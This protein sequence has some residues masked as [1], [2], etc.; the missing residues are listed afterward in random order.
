MAI[1]R[2]LNDPQGLMAA[3]GPSAVGMGSSEENLIGDFEEGTKKSKK[4]K[5]T[6]LQ[7]EFERIVNDRQKFVKEFSEKT[8]LDKKEIYNLLNVITK[9]VEGMK[10]NL[11]VKMMQEISPVIRKD[12]L[13]I[14]K[15]SETGKVQDEQKAIQ[16]LDELQ[17]KFNLD[18]NQFNKQLGGNLDKLLSAVDGMK[19]DTEKRIQ[20]AK[21]IQAE[22]LQKGRSTTI[23]N[24]NLRYLSPIEIKEKQQ[25]ANIVERQVIKLEK[26]L[27]KLTS[28]K[29]KE[30]TTYSEKEQQDRQRIR[31]R[32]EFNRE[33]LGGIKSEI[34]DRPE[35]S[36]SKF[37]RAI[38]NVGG[39][40]RGEK[41]PELI[42]TVIGGAYQTAISP[43]Y[44]MQ[45][46][47]QSMNGALLGL[48]GLLASKLG[49]L[50]KPI[51]NSLKSTFTKALGSLGD[52]MKKIGKKTLSVLYLI[53]TELGASLLAM[54]GS[55]LA[56]ASQF[57]KGGKLGKG[58]KAF[59]V[60]AVTSLGLGYA[61]DKAKESG[62]EKTG[63]ALDIAGTTAGYA[64]T[65]ALIGSVI[66]IPGVGPT[67]GAIVG[68][69]YGLYKGL[70]NNKGILSSQ[71]PN[72]QTTSL[73]KNAREKSLG[74][75]NLSSLTPT[76]KNLEK[77]PTNNITT[78]APN[79][80]VNN[81]TSF[82]SIKASI[83]NSDPTFNFINTVR[84]V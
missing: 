70:Q 56:A 67:V 46:I 39:F 62:Y 5:K 2:N 71:Q 24:G 28:T 65:G 49:N 15:L 11:V 66:P 79:N 80:L 58:V 33:K 48:P 61:S 16:K 69:G 84:V 8:G 18:L 14:I 76:D 55:A 77:S 17:R 74:V 37:G 68:G 38:S 54:A 45:T 34:G 6:A 44:A 42:R 3:L 50:F 30:G 21:N 53:L 4:S 25:R 63:A 81:N 10:R 9:K 12:L 23:S 60:S 73:M 19:E 47:L 78:I 59:G 1:T 64:G 41:G 35:G 43:F 83:I 31:E 52:S 26:E 27:D 51:F 29:P 57:L 20:E 40:V 32:I 22:E 13:D 82:S 75:Q 7:K 36:T 72:D